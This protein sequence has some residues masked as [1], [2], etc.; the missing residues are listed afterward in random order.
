MLLSFEADLDGERET[1][2]FFTLLSAQEQ[3]FCNIIF[4]SYSSVIEV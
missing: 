4:V 2:I 3:H 1:I